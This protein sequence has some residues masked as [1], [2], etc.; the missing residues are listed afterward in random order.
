MKASLF[1][2]SFVSCSYSCA[3]FCFLF[4]AFWPGFRFFNF[5]Y[6][7][8]ANI[9]HPARLKKKAKLSHLAGP[10]FTVCVQTDVA[11]DRTAARVSFAPDSLDLIALLCG[12]CWP[13]SGSAWSRQAERACA[14]PREGEDRKEDLVLA[15]LMSQL[16]STQLFCLINP[17]H[18]EALATVCHHVQ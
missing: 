14:V 4:L 16:G 17:L 6:C 1:S 11:P 15:F 7:D 9:L 3:V 12:T 5:K 18:V 13:R 8:P 2:S 10:R